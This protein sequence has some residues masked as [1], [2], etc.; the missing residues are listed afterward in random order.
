[1][2]YLLIS[3]FSFIFSTLLGPTIGNFIGW[4]FNKIVGFR[5]FWIG[6]TGTI[7]SYLLIS[8]IIQN[9][10]PKESFT[11]VYKIVAGIPILL[12]SLRAFY[13]NRKQKLTNSDK[14]G[15]LNIK[16]KLDISIPIGLIVGIIISSI[17]T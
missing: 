6:I 2:I 3:I 7:L 12:N 11:L 13:V 9:W 17:I 14:Y 1:M 15:E 5:G 8:Y 4:L 10:Y 16:M